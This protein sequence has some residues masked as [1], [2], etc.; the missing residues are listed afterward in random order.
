MQSDCSLTRSGALELDAL[1]AHAAACL[2]NLG[3][4]RSA[5]LLARLL[6]HAHQRADRD[7]ERAVRPLRDR[8]RRLDDVVEARLDAHEPRAS[9]ANQPREIAV[10][11]EVAQHAVEPGDLVHRGVSRAFRIRARGVIYPDVEYRAHRVPN[12]MDEQQLP[13]AV[14]R[15]DGR[16][17]REARASEA[18]RA[19]PGR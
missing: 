11:L 6:P 13:A 19:R 17:N 9:V 8:D 7:V 5:I 2:G 12:S 16:E 10:A 15:R 18:H 14:D 1:V 4:A 3:V